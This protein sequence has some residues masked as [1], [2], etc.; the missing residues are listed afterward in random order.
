MAC[1]LWPTGQRL[2]ITL[3]NATLDKILLLLSYI[4]TFKGSAMNWNLLRTSVIL[5]IASVCVGCGGAN[6]SAVS[7]KVTYNGEPV[8]NIQL[9]FSPVSDST[10][11]SLPYSIAVTDETGAFSLK[12]RDGKPG[13][14]VGLHKVGFAWPDIKSYTVRKLKEQLSES[15]DDPELTAEIEAKIDDA[16]KKMASRPTLKA[17]LKTEFTVSEGGTDGANFELT[18]F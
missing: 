13:A 9:V 12:T 6:Y 1:F 14:A 7:G 3:G 10:A 18:D 2:A 8:A 17:D 16:E 4:R 11:E 5:A 15:K